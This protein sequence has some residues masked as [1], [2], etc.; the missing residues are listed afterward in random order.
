MAI[1]QGGSAGSGIA[2][3]HDFTNHFP[4]VDLL[5]PALYRSYQKRRAISLFSLNER[6][7]SRQMITTFRPSSGG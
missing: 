2:T 7:A 1:C 6:S 4:V 5:R 3:H